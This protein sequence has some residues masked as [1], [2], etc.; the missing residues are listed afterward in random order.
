M[1]AGFILVTAAD[2][3]EAWVMGLIIGYAMVV[4]V[5][6]NSYFHVRSMLRRSLPKVIRTKGPVA[7]LRGIGTTLCVL[8]LLVFVGGPFG[9]GV[10][11][12]IMLSQWR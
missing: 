4:A 1:F 7:I 11:C 2:N 12:L 9:L 10:A 8:I 6:I 5:A 3:V